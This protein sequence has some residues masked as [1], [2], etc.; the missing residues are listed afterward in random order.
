MTIL[1][2]TIRK[3]KQKTNN[4]KTLYFQKQEIKKNVTSFS[5]DLIK[6]PCSAVCVG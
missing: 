4:I 2:V 6:I 1:S 3:K 5:D